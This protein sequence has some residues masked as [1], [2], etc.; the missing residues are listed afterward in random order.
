MKQYI[1]GL[2]AAHAGQR[3]ITNRPELI[4]NFELTSMCFLGIGAIV[5]SDFQIILNPNFD[6][7]FQ[8]KETKCTCLIMRL[9]IAKVDLNESK[10]KFRFE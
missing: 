6:I 7:N 2:L 4:Q 9:P 5:Y 1:P 3:F 8:K 10:P